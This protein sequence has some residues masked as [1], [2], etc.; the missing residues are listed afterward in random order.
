MD[1]YKQFLNASGKVKQMSNVTIY[2]KV[3]MEAS[4]S[5]VFQ[6]TC[7]GGRDINR[8]SLSKESKEQ[9]SLVLVSVDSVSVCVWFCFPDS[10]SSNTKSTQLLFEQLRLEGFVLH[11]STCFPCF[12]L[13]SL[14]I[15]ILMNKRN[16]SIHSVMLCI[17]V[18]L[19]DSPP[20]L[21]PDLQFKFKHISR[22]RG[23]VLLPV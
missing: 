22:E 16:T 9:K 15:A 6:S 14:L 8:Y 18:C 7:K 11:H 5:Q 20:I 12:S 13:L 21:T 3:F 4:V 2:S 10:L 1:H 17:D 19:L 23:Y